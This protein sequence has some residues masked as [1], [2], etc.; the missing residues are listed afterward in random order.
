MITPSSF[1]LNHSV[2]QEYRAILPPSFPLYDPA[3]Y[4]DMI[5]IDCREGSFLMAENHQ[6]RWTHQSSSS[7]P[8]RRMS[9][10]NI[11]QQLLTNTI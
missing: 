11:V 10:R 7:K 9:L 1:P 5:Q 6:R 8:R 2:S 4:L 3:A